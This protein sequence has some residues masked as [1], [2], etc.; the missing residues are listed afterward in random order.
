MVPGEGCLRSCVIRASSSASPIALSY[1]V[2]ALE[3]PGAGPV[4]C[5]AAVA[6]WVGRFWGWHAPQVPTEADTCSVSHAGTSKL[7]FQAHKVG[8]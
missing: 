7:A 1:C 2:I 6:A 8:W 5:T 4:A 3:C